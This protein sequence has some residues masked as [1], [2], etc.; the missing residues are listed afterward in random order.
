MFYVSYKPQTANFVRY[1]TVL[2]TD[3]LRTVQ[4]VTQWTSE[5]RVTIIEPQFRN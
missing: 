2:G 1:C 3:A 5:R 4:Y